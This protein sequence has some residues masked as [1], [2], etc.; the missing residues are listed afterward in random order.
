MT[1][2][3]RHLAHVNGPKR[4]MSSV[5]KF[6]RGVGVNDVSW[7]TQ[8]FDSGILLS[9][10][11]AYV[12]WANILQRC[13]VGGEYQ[14]KQPTYKEVT[15]C[16]S[17]AKFSSFS[18]WW[19]EHQVDGWQLDKDL[20]VPGNKV[21]SPETCIFVPSWLNSFTADCKASRGSTRIGVHFH[22][23]DKVFQANI[24]SPHTKKLEYLGYFSTEASAYNTWLSRK[25][26]YAEELRPQM[27]AIDLRLYPNV[28]QI[29]STT[30]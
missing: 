24:S 11:P 18:M 5:G 25:L 4:R 23:R 13:E 30:F 20:L 3:E 9:R 14:K 1:D 12:N 29:I 26:Q 28:V 2:L 16:Q 19:R 8:W 17:W 15:V 7:Q 6:V 22:N 10:D 27:D 21:Y